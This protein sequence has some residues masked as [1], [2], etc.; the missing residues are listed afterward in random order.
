L[1]YV[2][3]ILS[4]LTALTAVTGAIVS[5]RKI[6]EL[7][8]QQVW[9]TRA[10]TAE[11]ALRAVIRVC[12]G[13]RAACLTA[14]V[15]AE[16]YLAAVPGRIGEPDLRS[17]Q[18][19]LGQR[20]RSIADSTGPLDAE[21]V[22]AQTAATIHLPKQALAVVL[23]RGSIVEIREDLNKLQQQL[24]DGGLTPEGT[25]ILGRLRVDRPSQ[26]MD[27]EG[28]AQDHLGPIARGEK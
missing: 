16:A 18:Q 27:A 28:V 6:N 12:S 8:R 11:T 15:A 17:L 26:L 24:V 23:V 19:L 13:L 7:K 2:G 5:V 21:L 4:G 22:E 14:E 20:L 9:Q 3:D 10:K 1:S 25:R